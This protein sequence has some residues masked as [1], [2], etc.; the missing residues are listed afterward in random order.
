M[1]ERRPTNPGISPWAGDTRFWD[2][3]ESEIEALDFQDFEE[4]LTADAL[5]IEARPGF[6]EEL[7][8]E[9]RPLVAR[10]RS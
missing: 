2:D 1:G 10:R 5:P 6:Y 3:V 9:L 4:F 7:R 8:E